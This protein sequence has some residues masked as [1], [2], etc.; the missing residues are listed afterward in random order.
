[1]RLRISPSALGSYEHC[2]V[3]FQMAYIDKVKPM[4]RGTTYS[5]LGISVH[6]AIE[7]FHA[8]EVK[9]LVTLQMMFEG[10]FKQKTTEQLPMLPY[11]TYLTFLE[12]GKAML[13]NYFNYDIVQGNVKNV[14]HTEKKFVVDCG[15]FDLVGIV[16]RSY[17]FGDKVQVVDYK[18][19]TSVRSQ[20]DVD[21]D[22]QL[23]LY[24]WMY[25]KVLNLLPDSLCLHFLRSDKKVYTSRT[26][27]D[28]DVF[29]NSIV[30]F[31]D[32]VM[33]QTEFE[34]NFKG[35]G[36]CDYKFNCQAAKKKRIPL[37]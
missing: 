37:I 22:V 12:A 24:S 15:D 1:M 36:I 8:L 30:K 26:E 20:K 35:C 3:H 16:D 27:A 32:K 33:A 28:L 21:K 19:S 18:T 2:P 29:Y 9:D 25:R 31:K 4:F 5:I 13:I 6:E 7:K 34:P 17:Q 11:D 23:S 10:L 14:L